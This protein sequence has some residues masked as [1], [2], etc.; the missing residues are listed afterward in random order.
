MS[1]KLITTGQAAR[2]LGIYPLTLKKWEA[3]G[4]VISQPT[5][6][7]WKKYLLSDI[8]AIAKNPPNFKKGIHQYDIVGERFG[9]LV[10]MN[11][12]PNRNTRQSWW[13]CRCDCGREVEVRGIKLVNHHTKSCG[14]LKGS[15]PS[16]NFN[17]YGDLSGK[18][19]KQI[20]RHAKEKKFEFNLTK[21]NIW[22]LFQQQNK[23]CAISGLDIE[24]S[25]RGPQTASLDRID[26]NKGYCEDNVQWVH[27]DIQKLK[28]NFPE[29]KLLF[30]CKQVV[31]CAMSRGTADTQ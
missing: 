18:Y 25:R 28:S 11:R 22:H 17:G 4:V 19:W 6:G 8:E 26:S 9:S 5:S 10:V 3:R 16:Y 7:K 27:K 15:K 14:C 1:A 13:T 21:E 23:K 12:A 30:L 31:M 20:Q 24:L 2:I 29:E